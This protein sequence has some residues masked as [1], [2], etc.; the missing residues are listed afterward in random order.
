MNRLAMLV[1]AACVGLLATAAQAQE[2]RMT[3]GG[4]QYT[5][6]QA[7]RVDTPVDHDVFM[8]GYDVDLNGPVAGDAHLAGYNVVVDAAVTGDVYA[9]GFAVRLN[10]PIGG[11]ITAMANS[12]ALPGSDPVGGNV[13]LAGETITIGRQVSGAVMAA[14]RVLTLDSA[15]SGDMSFYGEALTF[16][17]A[18]RVDGILTIRA[19]REIAV[20]ATVAPAERVR[21]EVLTTPDY[22]SEAGKTAEHAVRSVWPAIWG[23]ALWWLFLFVTGA[24]II[25]LAPRR[26]QALEESAARR[27]FRNFLV[28]I[29]GFSAVVGL[30]PVFAMTLVGLV[31]LPFVLVFVVVACA[32][33]YVFG[34]FLVALRIMRAMLPVDSVAKRVGVLAVGLVAA[35]LLGLLPVLGWLIT[36]V[37]L[38]FGFG[39]AT[40]VMMRRWTGDSS[41]IA[42]TEAAS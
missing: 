7:V 8:A 5:A 22:V 41:R 15:V 39:A 13:R 18:A 2:S 31:L 1:A 4:D 32:L 35:F 37:L 19:P 3:L 29:L 6:G 25:A 30:V 14:A 23:A 20:P 26:V 27:P 17:P 11:D 33:A 10:A 34:A 38:V 28:G 12:I 36:L 40:V 16:G 21:F 42:A 24:A 9:A